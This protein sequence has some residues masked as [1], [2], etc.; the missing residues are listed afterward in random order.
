MQRSCINFTYISC[1]TDFGLVKHLALLMLCY[2]LPE[3]SQSLSI[4]IQH[5]LLVFLKFVNVAVGI[6]FVKSGFYP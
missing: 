5:W 1:S 2:N 3:F 6:F 4:F